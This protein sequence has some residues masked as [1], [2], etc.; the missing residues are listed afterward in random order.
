MTAK[1]HFLLGS[2]MFALSACGGSDEQQPQASAQAP[3]S[4]VN[5]PAVASYVNLAGVLASNKTTEIQILGENTASRGAVGSAIANSQATIGF[6]QTETVQGN[7][8]FLL[9]ARDPD[10]ISEIN[11]VLPSVNKSLPI[12]SSDCGNEYERSVIGLSPSI[13]GVSTGELRLEIWITDTLQNQV[14]ADAITFSWQP[15]QIVGVTAQRE[16]Q[17]I[18]LT[19]QANTELNRYNVYIAT[20]PGVSPSNVDELENG[21]QFLS[22]SDPFFTIPNTITNKSYQ[23]L[24][25]G[26]DG[27]GESGFSNLI[28]IAPLGGELAFAPTANNDIFEIDEDTALQG[29]VLTNDTNPY[30]GQLRANTQVLVAPSHGSV[31]MT[32]SGDFTYQPAFNFNGEDAFSYQI[33]NELGRTDTAVVAIT[34][35]PINDAPNALNNTYNISNDGTLTVSAPGLLGNDSDVDLD[36]LTVDVAPVNEPLRGQLTLFADGSFE[37]QGEP[38]MQGEDSFQ[39]KVID[40]QG[41]EATATV[42]IVSTNTNSAPVANNDS[43]NVNE[44]N[45]LVISAE[46]GVLSNDTDP[47]DDTFTVDD[48]FIVAPTHGQLLLSI[49]GSFSYIPDANFNGVDQFQYAAIDSQGASATAT[50]TIIVNSQPDNPVAQNDAYQFSRNS[51]FSVSAES[52][53][54]AND[55][56]IETGE[57]TVNTTPVTVPQN[58]TL[59]L[60]SDG[61]FTYQPNADFS[62]VD[63]FSYSI[64]ND[65]GL[66]ATAQVTLSESGNNTFPEASDDQFTIAEDSSATQLN[67]LANDTDADGDTITLFNVNSTLGSAS[68]VNGQIEYT[69]PANFSGQTVLTYS[70]TDGYENGSPGEKDSTASVTI[71]VTPVNDAPVANADFATINEDAIALLIDVLAND[72]DIDG[73]S[74]ILSEVSADSGTALIVENQI[75]YAPAPDANGVA[76]V[77]YSIKDA[78]DANATSTLSITIL[79]INDAP[80]ATADTATMDEDAAPI[81][82]DV[83]ANDSDVDGD[84]LVI[85]NAT[86]DVG[87]VSVV[88]N[89]IQ[90]TPAANANGVATVT[91]T[92]SDNNGGTANSTLAITIN[93]I[94]DAPVATADTANIDED[95]AP[96]TID[97]LAND[98]DVDGDSLVISNATADVGAVSVVNNQIQYTPA[99][100]ANGVATVTYTASDNNGGTASSTLAITINP[101]NDAPVAT[102]DTA[103]MNEDAAPITIDVLANDSDVDGDGLVISNTTA[104]VGAVSVVNNQIQ[105]APAANANGVAMVTYTASDNNGG[106]ANSTLAITINPINDAPVA[107]ADTATMDED[108]APITIDV[109][110]NDSDVDGDSLVISTASAD[111]G[112]ATIVN[113]QIQYT[114]AA[115]AN[116]VAT[117]IYTASDNNGGTASSTLAIAINPINDAPVATADTATM[118]EDAAPI[119]IDVLAN[120]SDVD[121]DS[122]V[123]STASADIGTA[124]IVNNQVQYTPADNTNGVATVTYTASDNN[125]GTAS[126]TLAITINPINDAPIATADTATMDEDAAPITIDVLANDSDVDGDSLVISNASADV[127]TATIV[128]NQIQYTPEANANGVATVAYTASDNNGGTA[129]STLAITINPINDAPIVTEQSFSINEEATD[130]DIIGTIVATDYENQDLTYVLAGGDLALFN[131]N[132]S[133]GIL[134][135]NG[136]TPFDYE[137]KTQYILNIQVTDNGTPNETTAVNITVNII[138]VVEPLI[139]FEDTSFGRPITGQLD[140]G[141]VFS[142]GQFNDSIALNNNLY[143]VGFTNNADKDI[144]IVSYTNNGDVNTAFNTT[145]TKVLD[146][147]QDEEATAIISDGTDL[148]IAYSSF[149]GSNNEACVLKMDLAGAL[150]T[151]SDDDGESNTGIKCTTLNSTS[152]INDLEVNG[153]ELV[154]VGKHF[155]GTQ[156]DSLWIHYKTDDLSFENST[157]AIVDVSGANRDDEGYAVKNF[158]NSDYLVVGSVTDADGTKNSLLRYLKA[159]GDNDGNFNG[160]VPLIIN[161]SSDLGQPDSNKDD[162]LFAIGGLANSNFTAFAGGYMTRQT[163]EKEAVMLAIDKNGELVTSFDTDGIAIYDID[164]ESG[165]TGNGVINGGAQVTGIQ[166][167]PIK[168]EIMLSGTTGIPVA[169]HVFT[170]RVISSTG[171]L[172]DTYGESGVSILSGIDAKQIVNTTSIDSNDTLWVAGIDDDTNAKPFIGAITDQAALFTNFNSTGYLTVDEISEA[173][174]DKSMKL[175]QLSNGAQAGKYMLASTAETNGV[176]KLVLTRFTST[177]AIDTSFSKTGHKEIAIELNSQH[178]ALAELN[179]GNLLLAGTKKTTN[180]SQGFV[181]KVDQDGS[182]D[183]TF[184]T[185]G[186]YVTNIENTEALTL[187][188]IAI[189]NSNNIV[190]VGTATQSANAQSFAMMLTAQGV[191]A[192]SFGTEGVLLGLTGEDFSK[193]HIDNNEIFIAGEL[194]TGADSAL[195]ALK[196][197]LTGNEL[198]RYSGTD[199]PNINNKV[200]SVLTDSSGAIY[201]VAN[202]VATPDKANVVRL[203]S[204]GSLDTSFAD[205]GVGQYSL[206]VTGN[207]LIKGAKLDSTDKLILV[208]TSNNQGVIA[209]ITTNGELDNTFGT[210]G[211][212]YYQANLCTNSLVFSSLILQTD[213][214]IALS[215]TCDNGSSNNISVSKFDFYPDGVEP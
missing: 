176:I 90:Y 33:I 158:E 96:I 142:G 57:L 208:G 150:R 36:E 26:I 114:P 199:T 139:P 79:P 87:A 91:Y 85:S 86:A 97:V 202:L 38:N 100:N 88:N 73:D 49:D 180:G 213:T 206:A 45:T 186:I 188:D 182:L 6:T 2:M 75:Q 92:A 175:I 144:L 58:G 207:T 162:E 16:D 137:T 68:I 110:A 52:G 126:S 179:N 66:T 185:D 209:R 8:S 155:D 94:N 15:H 55:F 70:I 44:D 18:N 194:V 211:V 122:L 183:T 50:V 109:L 77:T 173:S 136:E 20:Q 28:N 43:Y 84:S 159:N 46:N 7:V 215:S 134:S 25:T 125:G 189:T 106:T 54:L 117:V 98:S 27:S 193:I 64:S 174:N 82:I 99:A 210:S 40:N 164:G 184:A 13:Y 107:T 121:G 35:N 42:F 11:L 93:P 151:G 138:D 37:Y 80:V 132:A 60:N 72:S 153:S 145:G 161:L 214:Q 165:G 83:L 113:N 111:V 141:S 62:G 34:I 172:D 47:N 195:I 74:L 128:N 71:I 103:T 135:V 105:Y 198:F 104:D 160:G 61:S 115:N 129:N 146:L 143:F 51:L 123:I 56:N 19:W 169:E 127:G 63:S 22:I 167:E 23:A 131:I 76:T 101:I 212:G 171:L 53:L 178:V 30:S 3:T 205:N 14:L 181:A 147:E 192:T 190:A 21:Q 32:E 201:L 10:G 177:G 1:K 197:N 168:N 154:A 31:T 89:Q 9:N 203:L 108:A 166:Y 5:P 78:Q 196:L 133:S 12:C 200:A 17:G 187:S 124:T 59:N 81:A 170:A 102:A 152:V 4:T 140:L 119:T 116:G 39:Y 95:A 156:T 118:D 41:G 69:P 163:G 67:V 148:F 29:N 204:S 112:T 65:Q 191:L 149:D 157:P 48:T 130:S 120:D 24:I